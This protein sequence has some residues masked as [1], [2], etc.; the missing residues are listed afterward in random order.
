M[1]EI[2]T[3]GPTIQ[4]PVESVVGIFIKINNFGQPL[5]EINNLSLLHELLYINVQMQFEIFSAPLS[6]AEINNLSTTKHP[7]PQPRR[8]NGAP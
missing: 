1:L 4:S 2:C 6:R 8:L 3:K 7:P 5:H